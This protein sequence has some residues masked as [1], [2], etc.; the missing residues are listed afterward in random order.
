MSSSSKLNENKVVH[1]SNFDL[2]AIIVIDYYDGPETGLLIF[3]DRAL[4]KFSSAGDSSNRLSRAFLL[5]KV[6]KPNEELWSSIDALIASNKKQPLRFIVPDGRVVVT[7]LENSL[8]IETNLVATRFYIAS[9]PINFEQMSILEIDYTQF[10]ILSKRSADS[11]QFETIQNLIFGKIQTKIRRTFLFDFRNYTPRRRAL[12]NS[13]N[14]GDA[15][16][17]LDE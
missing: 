4:F 7:E 6:L 13:I 5:Q 14:K 12:A 3:P 1:L 17:C 16:L 9:C 8:K 10:S 15:T 11:S 2:L